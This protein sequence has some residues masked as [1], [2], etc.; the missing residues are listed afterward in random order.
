MLGLLCD[1]RAPWKVATLCFIKVDLASAVINEL[2]S[3]ALTHDSLN[4]CCADLKAHFRRP[5]TATH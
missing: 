5:Y 3:T 1:A 4:S 2:L